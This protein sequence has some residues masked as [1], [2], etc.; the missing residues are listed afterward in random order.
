MVPDLGSARRFQAELEAGRACLLHPAAAA[1]RHR[2]AA[3]GTRV[4]ADDHGRADPLSPDARLQ[5]AV[6]GRHR[7]CRHRHADRGRA[8]AQGR[9]QDSARSRPREVRRARVAME[10][11]VGSAI[12]H[13]MRR[14]GAAADWSRERFTMDDGMSKAVL[15]TFVRL[16]E[17]GLIYRGKRLV[18]WDPK[19]GTAVSDLEVESE[20]EQGK[21]WEIRYPLADGSRRLG[22]RRDDAARDD[23]RRHGGRGESRRRALS[24][25]RRQAGH[26]AVDRPHDSRRRRRFRGPRIRHGCSQGD[27]GARHERLADR[28]APRAAGDR[29]SRS[30]SEG[31]RQRT[32]KI[33]RHGSLRR[34]QGGARRPDCRGPAGV[35]KAAQ[36]GRPA[37]RPHRRS[38]RADADR[39]V[40]RRDDQ[41]GAG[42]ASAV[43]GQVDPGSLPRRGR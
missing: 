25:L 15:E 7:P 30:R 19:L 37:L 42:Y 33:P 20:E 21:L 40:V 34:A 24:E 3:H 29:D 4:P 22:C 18:N 36:D 14:L 12:T 8:T 31:Q 17:D 11:G 28:P 32:R 13:Q 9:R 27:A 16:H 35:R 43:A 23:A 6:A 41:D 2:H 5:H 1:E 26:A 39:P 10:A 38:R